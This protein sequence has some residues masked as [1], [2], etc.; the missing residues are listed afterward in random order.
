MFNLLVAGE[1]IYKEIAH[2]LGY[3]YVQASNADEAVSNGIRG[4]VNALGSLDQ[5][6]PIIHP[7]IVSNINTIE[8]FGGFISSLVGWVIKLAVEY[9]YTSDLLNDTPYIGELIRHADSLI[10]PEFKDEFSSLDAEMFSA[11]MA[12]QYY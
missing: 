8:T 1:P 9:F 10:A 3:D 6:K 2:S 4:I 12:N 11:S 5:F 7:D